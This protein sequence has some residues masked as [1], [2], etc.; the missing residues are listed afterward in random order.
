MVLGLMS[1][2]GRFM[3]PL[4]CATGQLIK[5]WGVYGIVLSLGFSIL[6]IIGAVLGSISKFSGSLGG[7]LDPSYMVMGPR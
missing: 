5:L 7:S 6:G 1:P 4:D 2:R 3:G